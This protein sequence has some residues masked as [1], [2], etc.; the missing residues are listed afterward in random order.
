MGKDIVDAL[1][2]GAGPAGLSAAIYLARA[3]RSAVVLDGGAGRSTGPQVNE[4]YL[5]FPRGV[6]AKRLRALGRRQAERFGAR[7]V[8]GTVE[9]AAC[10][11]EGVFTLAGDCGEWQGHAV[12][13]ATGVTDI[14]PAIPKV[15]RYVGR[16][17]FWCIVC[18]GFRTLKRRTLLIGATDEAATTACQFLTYTPKLTFVA[19]GVGGEL[20]I[21]PE[22]LA[23][24]SDHGID[25]VE[26]AID[27]VEGARG[28]I[29]RAWVGDTAH[30]VDL[31]FSLLGQVPNSALAASLGAILDDKGYVR[32]DREQRTNVAC[33]YAAGDVT[34]PYAHQVTS[35]VHEGA[36]A[37]QAA[38]W[39]LYPAF[40]R[41]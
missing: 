10:P 5:G 8:E 23:M 19:T 40:Q 6:T 25:V 35:A 29:R 34:G 7:F 37:A 32:I 4:N 2:V 20:Q 30:D 12:I 14:W 31:V 36:M 24:M 39:D 1:I 27:R 15:E 26:G 13:V 41:E 17:L 18:D 22:K 16:S 38:N 21:S 28:Q 33:V 9:S 11:E 3:R